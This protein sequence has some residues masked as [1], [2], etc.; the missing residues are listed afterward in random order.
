MPFLLLLILHPDTI[1]N[2][3]ERSKDSAALAFLALA[4][5]YCIKL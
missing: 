3:R 1:G 4:A 2:N 5:R